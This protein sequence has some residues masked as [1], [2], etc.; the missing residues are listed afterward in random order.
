MKTPQLIEGHQMIRHELVKLDQPG[1]CPVCDVAV[2]AGWVCCR[3]PS[4]EVVCSA[5]C[6]SH[7]DWGMDIEGAEIDDVIEEIE[8]TEDEIDE[9][10]D[11]ETFKD[12]DEPSNADEIDRLKRSLRELK[13]RLHHLKRAKRLAYGPWRVKD[14]N[15]NYPP[16]TLL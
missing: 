14:A 9:L 5:T 11:D 2:P 1:R 15:N 13:T 8:D 7:T 16:S 10:E 6:I 4:G 3:V 12:E